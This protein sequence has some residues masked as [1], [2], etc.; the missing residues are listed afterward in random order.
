[1]GAILDIV[2]SMVIRAVI[3]LV[4]LNLNVSLQTALY[5]KTSRAVVKQSVASTAETFVSDMN[6]LGYNASSPIETATSN[7]FQFLGDIDNNGSAN[8]VHYYTATQSTSPLRLILYRQ[9]DGGSSQQVGRD[10]DSLTFSYYDSNGNAMPIPVNVT[11]VKSIGL[12]FSVASKDSF[13]GFLNS[14]SKVYEGVWERRF[15]PRNLN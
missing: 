2:G 9:I 3:V 10:I 12:H 1:M 13:T 11:N 14:D 8:V 4:M 7:D 6:A 5:Q 15:F